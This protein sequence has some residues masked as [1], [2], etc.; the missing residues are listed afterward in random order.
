MANLTVLNKTIR[1]LDGLYS[2]N[3]LHRAS[4]K[5]KKHQAALF[6]RSEQTK[7]LIREI[8]QSTDLYTAPKAVKT[9]VG[10]ANPGTW[11]C[12][13]L[14]YAYAMWISPKFHL[15]VIRAF[16]SM[17]NSTQQ[18]SGNLAGEILAGLLDELVPN[19]YHAAL[20]RWPK[21]AKDLVFVSPT[22]KFTEAA[23]GAKVNWWN[24]PRSSYGMT[25]LNNL[26][27]AIC[28]IDVAKLAASSPGEALNVLT[29]AILYCG[30]SFSPGNQG[31]YGEERSFA[32]Y[33][34]KAALSFMT[35]DQKE[36]GKIRL[37]GENSDFLVDIPVRLLA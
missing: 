17:F 27:G 3:D 5:A 13:E 4:G 30:N 33:I 8:E 32:N 2:L 22:D 15:M 10:G 37:S 21:H 35:R 14:V 36:T 19:E 7:E 6:L 28:A 18:Q 23:T 34:A 25:E 20:N 16:D 31:L 26:A 29:H 9:K 1:Q 12:K 24:P 11:V